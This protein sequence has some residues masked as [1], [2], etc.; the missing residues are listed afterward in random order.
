MRNCGRRNHSPRT[1]TPEGSWLVACAPEG[2]TPQE[3]IR[4][5]EAGWWPMPQRGPLPQNRYAWRK[6]VGG[7]CPRRD[8]SPRTDTP[9]GSWLMAYVPE[10]TTGREEGS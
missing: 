6:L 1:D 3:P 2:T 8:H 4:L 5:E 9:G 10:G 7:L